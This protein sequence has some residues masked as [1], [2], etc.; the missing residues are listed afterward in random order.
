MGYLF[1]DAFERAQSYSDLEATRQ[2][3]FGQLPQVFPE[4]TVF[5]DPIINPDGTVEL[6]I[7]QGFG[8][9][10]FDAPVAF[11]FE[12]GMALDIARLRLNSRGNSK[13]DGIEN[14]YVRYDI[15]RGR[16]MLPLNMQANRIVADAPIGR[17]VRDNP[18]DYHNHLR[19]CLVTDENPVEYGP[20]KA[21]TT[22]WDAIEAMLEGYEASGHPARSGI[23]RGDLEHLLSGL[24][25]LADGRA[26]ER[27]NTKRN[28]PK[29]TR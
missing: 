24:L 3:S 19:E 26:T 28:P 15:W 2:A 8:R 20:G 4:F 23:P 10:R 14:V 13:A 9:H 12:L 21:R 7:E 16:G 11:V 17:R 29:E 1:M 5:K 25:V 18:A 22:R 27:A 6:L